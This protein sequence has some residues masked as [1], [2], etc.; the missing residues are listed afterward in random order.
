MEDTHEKLL[1]KY[2]V[3][4][5]FIDCYIRSFE[6]RGE[7]GETPLHLAALNGELDD[8]LLML[9]TIANIDTPGGIGHTALHYAI[10]FGHASIVDVLLEHGAS[11]SIQNE[12]G[13]RP[14][15]L[16]RHNRADMLAT[17][18]KHRPDSVY[19]ENPA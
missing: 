3:H 6:D 7:D 1:E 17:I 13:D 5:M 19:R 2:R 16:L 12:Y 18:L 8:L 10:M 14:F 9:P 4:E 15:D 11:L